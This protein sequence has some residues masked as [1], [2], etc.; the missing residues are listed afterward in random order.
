[1]WLVQETGQFAHSGK[2]DR[3]TLAQ[4]LENLTNHVGDLVVR[5]RRCDPGFSSEG[6]GKFL[7]LHPG[8]RLKAEARLDVE[9]CS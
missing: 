8:P 6:P 1:M 4:S 2:G 5:R 7:L 3:L 9:F